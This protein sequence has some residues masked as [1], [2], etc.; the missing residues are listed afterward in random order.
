MPDIF[1]KAFGFKGRW[2]S[3]GKT[4]EGGNGTLRSSYP[5]IVGKIIG[6]LKI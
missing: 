2:Q 6:K 4:D 3:V 5:T 1:A